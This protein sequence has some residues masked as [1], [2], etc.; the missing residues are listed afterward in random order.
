MPLF[1]VSGGIN[2][3]AD[4]SIEQ[5]ESKQ[6]L[7]HMHSVSA[8]TQHRQAVVQVLC[9]SGAMF[10]LGMHQALW[11]LALL[12]WLTHCWHLALALASPPADRAVT[13]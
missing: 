12:F 4:C 1:H 9:C 2:L 6:P 10:I 13:C 5:Y 7:D 8:L 11:K 3:A